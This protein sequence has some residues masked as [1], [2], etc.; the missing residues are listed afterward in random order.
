MSEQ[1]QA[2]ADEVERAARELGASLRGAF[3]LGR[4]RAASDELAFEARPLIQALLEGTRAGGDADSPELREAMALASLLG[5]RVSALGATPTCALRVAPAVMVAV[6]A[7]A[8]LE[9]ALREVLL[10]GYVAEREEA[11][12]AEGAR[13]AAEA[14]AVLELAPR[15]FVSFPAGDQEAEQLAEHAEALGRRLLDRDAQVLVVHAA[16]L[17]RPDPARAAQLFAV[18]ASCTMLGVRCLFAAVPP[19]WVAAARERGVDLDDVR[20][21]DRLEP[22]LEEALDLCGY[23][24]GPRPALARMWRRWFAER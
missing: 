23:T 9:A 21:V 24:L 3:S 18:Q 1:L 14:I 12:R 17:G 15:C 19:G 16:G 11:L 10:E 22:A 2:L 7:A 13:R 8:P 4:D 20:L 6:P 5:R